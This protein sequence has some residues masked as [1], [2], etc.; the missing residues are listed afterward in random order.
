MGVLES[1]TFDFKEIIISSMNEGILPSGKSQNSLIPLHIKKKFNLPTHKEKDAI[2]AYH[3]YRLLQRAEKVHLIYNSRIDKLSGGEKSRFLEQLLY[4]GPKKNPQLQIEEVKVKG[5]QQANSI[6]EQSISKNSEVLDAIR[7]KISSGLSPSAINTYLECPLNFYYSY[8]LGLREEDRTEAGEEIEDSLFGT[9]LHDALEALYKE[10]TSQ[11][12]DEKVMQKIRSVA[13]EALEYSFEKNGV[14]NRTKGKNKLVFEVAAKY[15]DDFFNFEEQRVKKGPI[16]LINVEQEVKWE[17]E[18]QLTDGQNIPLLLRG[19]IDRIEEHLGVKQILDYKSGKVAANDL[20][21]TDIEKLLHS[22]ENKYG[23]Q[24]QLMVYQFLY[25]Q[26]HST[27][28]YEAGIISFK[29]LRSGILKATELESGKVLELVSKIIEDM[30]DTSRS[31]EH[32]RKSK[33]CKF[34]GDL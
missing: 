1:R 34:C 3:F 24:L 33:Y 16:R 5:L 4:E 22:E 10:Y 26:N 20:K 31:F 19:K 27:S 9:L 2:F 13:R 6:Y 21:A 30:L 32:N 25:N 14:H 18:I 7:K 8:I 29:A 23:K 11:L 28:D 17:T 12:I 15:L